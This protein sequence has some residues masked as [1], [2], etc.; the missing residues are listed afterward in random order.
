MPL[1]ARPI[2]DQSLDELEGL[3]CGPPK[4]D[5]D[6]VSNLHRLRRVPLKQYRIEDLRLMIGQQIG[7][8]YLVPRALD[9]LESHPLASGDFYRGDLL[10]SVV[11][12]SDGFWLT[13]QILIPRALAA[14][15][16]ALARVP[17]VETS[18]K[19]PGELRAARARLAALLSKSRDA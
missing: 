15:D 7:L 5:S 8:D 12:L 2:S 16:A 19:L 18:E 1:N 11:R 14:I 4:F 6:L 3:E 9:H 10:A 17:N 13:H